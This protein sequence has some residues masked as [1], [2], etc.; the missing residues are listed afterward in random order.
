MSEEELIEAQAIAEIEAEE[1]AK[2]EALQ[3][4]KELPKQEQTI[5]LPTA[6]PQEPT[7]S[8]TDATETQPAI[9]EQQIQ[10]K[11]YSSNDHFF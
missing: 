10:E 3:K 9:S 2:K 1:R 4:I 7:H 5:Q 8:A 11:Y 6:T